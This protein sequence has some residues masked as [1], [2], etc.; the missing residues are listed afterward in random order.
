[1]VSDADNNNRAC[2]HVQQVAEV[3]YCREFLTVDLTIHGD[4][5]DVLCVGDKEQRKKKRRRIMNIEMN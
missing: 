1:M 5:V 2:N 3:H 4:D